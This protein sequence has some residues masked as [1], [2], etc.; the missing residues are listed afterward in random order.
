MDLEQMK[1]QKI[2]QFGY[3][4]LEAA[5][6]RAAFRVLSGRKLNPNTL[7]TGDQF[8]A[9]VKEMIEDAKTYARDVIGD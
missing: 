5:R 4:L 9:S 7:I 6:Y 3:V 8:E 2:A 1:Q